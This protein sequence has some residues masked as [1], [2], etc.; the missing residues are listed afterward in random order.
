MKIDIKQFKNEDMLFFPIRHHSLISSNFLK[1]AIKSFK[2]D[3]ILIEGPSDSDHFMENIA[4]SEM[5][6]SIYGNIACEEI[7]VG[8]NFP[9]FYSSP[10][11]IAIEHAYK[12]KIECHFIDLPIYD[13]DLIRDEKINFELSEYISQVVGNSGLD[14]FDEYYEKHFEIGLRGKDLETYMKQMLTLCHITR[15]LCPS[16]AYNDLRESYMAKKIWAYKKKRTLVITGGFHSVIMPRLIEKLSVL[17]VLEKKEERLTAHNKN[18]LIPYNVSRISSLNGY[19]AGIY[20]PHYTKILLKNNLN[21]RD[22]FVEVLTSY[23]KKKKYPLDLSKVMAGVELAYGLAQLRNKK[24]PGVYELFDA[25]ISSFTTFSQYN[26][27]SRLMGDFKNFLIGSDYGR[28]YDLS[29]LPPIVEDFRE[30]VIL[31]KFNKANTTYTLNVVSNRSAYKRSVFLSRLSYLGI[32]FAVKEK[33]LDLFNI[34]MNQYISQTYRISSVEKVL[35]SLIEIA[36]LGQ[37]IHMALK[38]KVKLNTKEAKGLSEMVTLLKECVV[39]QL[40]DETE[41]LIEHIK[42]MVMAE[43]NLFELTHAFDQVRTMAYYYELFPSK[44]D[45]ALDTLVNDLYIKLMVNCKTLSV[46]DLEDEKRVAHSINTVYAFIRQSKNTTLE[47]SLFEECLM[48]FMALNW[49]SA[50]KG[51]SLSILYSNGRIKEEKLIRLI[52]NRLIFTESAIEATSQFLTYLLL[53]NYQVL[54]NKKD[55]LKVLNQ[56]VNRLEEEN[57]FKLLPYLRKI[58]TK[59]RPVETIKLSKD[60]TRLN[61]LSNTPLVQFDISEDR[62]IRNKEIEARSLKILKQKGVIS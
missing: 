50:L 44:H 20:Y 3:M 34:N 31:H 48:G 35:P 57:F 61:K 30:Q 52:E 26:D 6:V 9:F 4:R 41:A 45:K 8:I 53:N 19:S 13:S 49:T 62:F 42:L 17:P 27:S 54:L 5:P 18:Y 58:F 15:V 47:K 1:E 24:L 7:K 12:K 56:F 39:L 59:L 37:D 32:D 55:F 10:E 46:M 23:A 51:L 25:A 29:S 36:F 40:E 60:L 33:G 16:N 2:P 21:P 28:V 11:Y 38:S 14:S 22:T 43:S